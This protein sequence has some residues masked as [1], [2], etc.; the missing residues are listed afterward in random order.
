MLHKITPSVPM[1]VPNEPINQNLIEVLKVVKP[2][3]K[4]TLLENFGDLCNKQPN[5]PSLPVCVLTLSS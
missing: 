3:N 2:T 4:K 1:N 5:V